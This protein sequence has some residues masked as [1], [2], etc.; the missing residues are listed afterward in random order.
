[1]VIKLIDRHPYKNLGDA[2]DSDNY[3]QDINIDMFQLKLKGY[4]MAIPNITDLQNS[5]QIDSK[6][7]KLEVAD[8]PKFENA[9]DQINEQ[10]I[11]SLLVDN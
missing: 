10:E 9:V 8:V 6:A 1:M 7:K 2:A 3:Q 4:K 11:A 5:D